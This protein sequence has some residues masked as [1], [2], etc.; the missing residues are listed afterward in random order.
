[1]YVAIADPNQH[2]LASVSDFGHLRSQHI[3]L[4][5]VPVP[6]Y[7]SNAPPCETSL[8]KMTPQHNEELRIWG[9]YYRKCVSFFYNCTSHEIR[10]LRNLKDESTWRQIHLSCSHPVEKLLLITLALLAPRW[11][12]SSLESTRRK[13]RKSRTRVTALRSSFPAHSHRPCPE[14]CPLP[15]LPLDSLSSTEG[16][17]NRTKKEELKMKRHPQLTQRM[18]HLPPCCKRLFPGAGPYVPRFICSRH[19]PCDISNNFQLFI[20]SNAVLSLLS[21]Q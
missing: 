20:S 6:T 13:G 19:T 9:S 16:R 11:S 15:H 21:A 7:P 17:H 4:V 10:W 1:M 3:H 8:A 2:C 12:Y 14:C 18:L 5:I